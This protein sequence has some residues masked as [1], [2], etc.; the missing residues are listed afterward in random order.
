MIVRPIC[1]VTAGTV[2]P[3]GDVTE[4]SCMSYGRRH[5]SG[6]AVKVALYLLLVNSFTSY[7]KR[8]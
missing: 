6:C 2:H 7:V 1:D 5:C 3:I 4:C 8:H